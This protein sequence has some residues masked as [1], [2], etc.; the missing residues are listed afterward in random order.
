MTLSR[1]AS[2]DTCV[3]EKTPETVSPDIQQLLG[4]TSGLRK[5]LDI[6]V[7]SEGARK[8]WSNLKQFQSPISC[9]SN[10][11]TPAI[12]NKIAD[13]VDECS[14]AITTAL[15]AA[16]MGRA[17]AD[18][19]AALC[20]AFTAYVPGDEAA[21]IA[22]SIAIADKGYGRSIQAHGQLICVRTGLSEVAS[23][24]PSQVTQVA[25][26]LKSQ[27]PGFFND[28][29]HAIISVSQPNSPTDEDDVSDTYPGHSATPYLCTYP[30]P[31][32]GLNYLTFQ[33]IMEQLNTIVADLT[34]FIDRINRIAIWLAKTKLSLEMLVSNPGARPTL[35]QDSAECWRGISD[36]FSLLIYKIGPIV[37]GFQPRAVRIPA[38]GSQSNPWGMGI[39]GV[40]YP[41]MPYPP[42][43]YMG[44][45]I[46]PAPFSPPRR[47]IRRAP[48]IDSLEPPIITIPAPEMPKV[49]KAALWRR[50][51]CMA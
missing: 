10:A 21:L 44:A 33:V 25:R 5:E 45:H 38:N 3:F 4:E 36:Q 35:T 23:K 50:I 26:E 14:D 28:M 12:V 32:A 46:P 37:S 40:P 13:R 39:P 34:P 24:I 9:F 7:L 16:Q 29:N 17:F 30:P 31:G 2:N 22:S 51:L 19:M 42:S 27:N 1:P 15:G 41:A 49:K 43:P 18:N 11:V 8:V 48:S 6:N 47:N 20:D